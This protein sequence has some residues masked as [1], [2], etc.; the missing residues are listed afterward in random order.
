MRGTSLEVY[1]MSLRTRSNFSVKLFSK[2]DTTLGN[3]KSEI[4]RTESL[5]SS[6]LSQMIRRILNFDKFLR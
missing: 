4:E 3:C 5:Y 2:M 6:S 1:L